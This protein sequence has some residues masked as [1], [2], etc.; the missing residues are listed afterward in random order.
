[1]KPYRS[2]LFVPGHKPSWA[3][4]AIAAGADAIILDLEDSVP[5]TDKAA[6]RETV[7]E[8]IGRLR[9]PG[10][11][12]GVWVRPNSLDGGLFGADAEAVMVPGLAGLL[13]PKVFAAEEIVRIDAIVSHIDADAWE[14]EQV[15]EESERKVLERL[16]EGRE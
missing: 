2:M 12:A 5:A 4:K 3:E 8:T 11:R 9:G 13:L 1:M 6:A 14:K 10:P 16:I 7:R 15:F